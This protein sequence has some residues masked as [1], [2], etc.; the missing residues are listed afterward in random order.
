MIIHL[1][2]RLLLLSLFILCTSSYNYNLVCLTSISEIVNENRRWPG[3]TRRSRILK[4]S[5]VH[6]DDLKKYVDGDVHGDVHDADTKYGLPIKISLINLAVVEC[7]SLPQR[8]ETGEG[9]QGA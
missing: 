7:W 8:V 1:I 9:Q 4:Q 3:I 2:I 6:D 5:D